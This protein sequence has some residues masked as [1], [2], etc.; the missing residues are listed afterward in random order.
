MKNE[1]DILSADDKKEISWHSY[2]CVIKDLVK[3]GK[4]SFFTAAILIKNTRRSL[5]LPYQK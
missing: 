4:L 3:E 1:I 5:G 2:K